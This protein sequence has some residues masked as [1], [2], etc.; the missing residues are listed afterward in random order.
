MRRL[1]FGLAIGLAAM[2]PALGFAGD[3]EVAQQIAYNLKNSGQMRGYS[4]GVKVNGSTA[5]LGGTVRDDQQLANALY[6]A[7][8]TPGIENVVNH[9]S[10]VPA[11]EDDSPV[12]KLRQP[13]T[14]SSSQSQNQAPAPMAAPVLQTEY[15][16]S[17]NM[18]SVSANRASVP[19]AAAPNMMPTPQARPIAAQTASMQSMPAQY[20]PPGQNYGAMN[21]VGPGTQPQPMYAP[22]NGGGVAAASYDHPNMPNY[23]WPSYAAYPNY[24]AIT[25][26]RQYSATAWPYI[27]PFYP[28]PQVPLGW[29]KVSLEWEDGWWFL[30]FCDDHKPNCHHCGCGCK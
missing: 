15:A 3:K 4:I 29:R 2:S 13:I 18:V 24:A 12:T 21:G 7:K 9:L 19:N 28:Y 23:A 11:A 25:Y 26:P 6:L 17:S 16:Q 30:D 10:V 20:C 14:P 1:F 8:S 22:G 27:G 5:E